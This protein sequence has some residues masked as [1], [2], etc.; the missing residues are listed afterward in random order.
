MRELADRIV[1]LYER[2]SQ[3]W[4]RA[5]GTKLIEAAWLERFRALLAPQGVVLDLGCGSG[6]P[7][8]RYFV[9]RGFSVVGVDSS[10]AMIALF[11]RNLPEQ[12]A[13]GAD[14]RSLVLH[15]V[16]DGLMAWDSFFHLSPEHQRAM[17]PIF[18]A[19]TQSGAPLL[20]TSG[21][22]HGEAIGELEGEPLYHA[23]LAPA[24]YRDLMQAS[25]FECIA[26][27]AEDPECG[28]HTVWLAQR[29]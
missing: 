25:G 9:E 20:F 14:M 18:A 12:E 19:H 28:R 5:R 22:E 26:H 3:V 10:P 29:R 15:R 17:F 8:A 27:L 24:E 6:Q 4:T 11:R 2:H 23:S 13:L 21:P 1:G 7:L 16:F